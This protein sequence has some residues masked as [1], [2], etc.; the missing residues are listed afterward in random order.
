MRAIVIAAFAITLL[1]GGGAVAQQAKDERNPLVEQ[2]VRCRGEGDQA[3]R[4]QCYDAAVDALSKATDEGAVVV[5]N[6]EE[7]RETRRSLFGFSLPKLPLFRGDKTS[8]EEE[9]QEIVAKIASVRSLGYGKYL[10]VLDTGARWQTTDP[11]NYGPDPAPGLPIRIKRGA[12]G[13]YF[14]SIDGGR[15]VKGMRTG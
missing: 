1:A 12:I 6:R 11:V 7:V 4:V 5:V 10:I 14:I 8:E 3:T 9:Q 13:S 2:L 15:A